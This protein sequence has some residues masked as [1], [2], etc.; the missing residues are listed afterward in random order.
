MLVADTAEGVYLSFIASA[1]KALTKVA[2]ACPIDGVMAW[3]P[4]IHVPSPVVNVDLTYLK[5]E[6]DAETIAQ[7]REMDSRWQ[8]SRASR[9]FTSETHISLERLVELIGNL[10]EQIVAYCKQLEMNIK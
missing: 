8:K 2:R 3:A 6:L 4:K 10:E 9:M 1:D 5:P 7:I